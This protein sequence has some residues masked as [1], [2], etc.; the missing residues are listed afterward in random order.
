MCILK[1][2]ECQVFYY[3]CVMF[4]YIYIYIYIYIKN[5]FRNDILMIYQLK[6]L[7]FSV[8][9]RSFD[10]VDNIAKTEGTFKGAEAT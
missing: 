3:D 1:P 5:N 10:I 2:V 6:K 8:F 4:T 7:E 9:I